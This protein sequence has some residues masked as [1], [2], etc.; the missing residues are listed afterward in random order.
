MEKINISF[1]LIIIFI[2][3]VMYRKIEGKQKYS[4]KSSMVVDTSALI[5]GRIKDLAQ[6]GFM[7]K[8]L[9]IPKVVIR[10]LQ[11]IADGRDSFKRERARVGL[12]IVADLQN[13][14]N[15]K[16][17][18]DGYMFGSKEKTDEI[19]IHLSKKRNASLCTT[20]LNL[21]K[22]AKSEAISVFNVNE[23]SQMMRTILLP[24]EDVTVKIIQKGETP[25][26]GVGYLDD[27]TMVVVEPV[28]T[29]MRNK[30]VSAKV[31]RLI[32]TKAGKMVFA[33]IH[34]S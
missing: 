19:L 9:I 18:I 16:V 24:G 25:M 8:E 33:H 11:L 31:V 15:V 6:L 14:P 10:E 29:K 23:L 34:N 12:D 1:N 17:Q 5:D 13:M 21:N 7:D 30:T 2:L 3:L 28:T 26:Q 27:G 20:D 32:H 4:K 22:V